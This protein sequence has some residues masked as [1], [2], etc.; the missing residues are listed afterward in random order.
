MGN[1]LDAIESAGGECFE[2]DKVRVGRFFDCPYV[3]YEAY[4][5]E[6]SA[7]WTRNS[8]DKMRKFLVF[9]GSSSIVLVKVA[10][11]SNSAPK[12]IC[13]HNKGEFVHRLNFSLNLR[14]DTTTVASYVSF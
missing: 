6:F 13:L 11:S 8:N 3:E 14:L 2:R 1:Y 10:T 9:E 7:H 4:R 12:V 5:L